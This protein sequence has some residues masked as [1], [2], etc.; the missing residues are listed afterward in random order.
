[1]SRPSLPADRFTSRELAVAAELTTRN[2]SLLVDQRLA[3][4]PIDGAGGRGGH[5]SYDSVGLG[6]IALL[7]AFHRAGME[8]L[9]AARLAG[10]VAEDYCSTYGRLPSNLAA[11]LQHPHNPTP[12][13]APWDRALPQIEIDDDYWLHN[14]LRFH[15]EIYKPWKALRG[16]LV[17]E[18]VDQT[19]VLIRY[20]DSDIH[21][22]SPVSD[23]LSASPEYR[24][25][26]RGAAARISPIHEGIR[27]FDFSIDKESSD[28]LRARQTEYLDARENA[29]TQLRINV[30]LAIR[31]GLDRVADDRAGRARRPE[32]YRDA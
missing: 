9:I 26:G 15:T 27:S 16:D 32:V 4:Q 29:V 2:M 30:A 6:A 31:N 17:V 21:I 24:I 12:G 19:Y 7:G 8:L 23:V 25:K 22:T 1:M 18:I 14:R 11:Y 20:H 3:P 5:R 10:A 13:W 28:T